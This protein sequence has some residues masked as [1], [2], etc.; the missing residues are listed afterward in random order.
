M[1]K[2]N[3]SELDF[4]KGEVFLTPIG[5]GPEQKV[6]FTDDV[7]LSD[8]SF[9]ENGNNVSPFINEGD[10]SFDLKPARKL[11]RVFKKTQPFPICK[12][13]YRGMPLFKRVKLWCVVKWMK[14]K[15]AKCLVVNDNETQAFLFNDINQ[16]L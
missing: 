14:L 10:I 8:A 13:D 3:L 5:G 4:G 1:S 15:H 12:I 7:I 16:F 6:G 9:D 2:I 11:R